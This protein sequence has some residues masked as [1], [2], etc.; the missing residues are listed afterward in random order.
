MDALDRRILREVQRDSSGS[1]A[2]LAERCGTTESTALRRMRKLREAGV[3]RSQVAIV[4]GAKIG[5]GLL[6][7]V[8]VRL[9]R[10]DSVSA[11]AFRKRI[12]AH[13]DVMQFYFVTGTPDYVI[14]LS[15]RSMDDYYGFVE[16]YLVADPQVVLAD[17]NVVIRPL[18][19]STAIPVDEP[20]R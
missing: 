4:D 1:A 2:D 3:I 6:L 17:T 9:E 18:K 11:N 10:D 7:F 13:P 12:I 20:A 14:L 15:A 5:R 8:T 19:M 16:K